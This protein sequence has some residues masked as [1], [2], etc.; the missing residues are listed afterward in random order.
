M[1]LKANLEILIAPYNEIMDSYTSI[2]LPLISKCA[3][4]FESTNTAIDLGFKSAVIL[5]SRLFANVNAFIDGA[6]SMFLSII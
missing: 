4:I 2:A 5:I 3:E 1:A 6:S